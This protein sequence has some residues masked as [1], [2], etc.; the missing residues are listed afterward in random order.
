MHKEFVGCLTLVG[1]TTLATMIMVSSSFN[2][3]A[4]P[5]TSTATATV[6]VVSACSLSATVDSAH[7]A[8]L[9]NGIYS[10]SSDYPNGIGQT[11]LTAFCNDASGF[12]IYAVGFSGDEYGVK[13]GRAHV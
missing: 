1:M 6:R 13:I 9:L 5:A 3:F 10:G 11:T 12:A 8:T 4:E 7:N 2:A